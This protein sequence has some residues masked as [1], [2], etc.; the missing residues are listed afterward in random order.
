MGKGKKNF[1]KNQQT[2]ATYPD[3]NLS[4]AELLDAFLKDPEV[5]AVARVCPF[6]KDFELTDIS[7]AGR[8]IKNDS[9]I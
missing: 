7:L 6:Q 1:K 9:F 5:K 3:K 4:P 8:G 2:A